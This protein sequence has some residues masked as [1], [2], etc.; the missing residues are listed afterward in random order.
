MNDSA[1]N[2]DQKDRKPKRGRFLIRCLFGLAWLAVLVVLF[3]AEENWRGARALESYKR[4]LAARGATLDWKSF[5]PPPVPD[6]ENFAMT[7]FLAPLFDF[8][9]GT[10]TWRDIDARNDVMSFA[11][12]FPNIPFEG[13]WRVGNRINLAAW[14]KEPR[15]KRKGRTAEIDQ[16]ITTE[17]A[18]AASS[19]LATLAEYDP[20]IE[21]L[22]TASQRSQSR[23][24]IRYD[25]DDLYSIL[26]PHLAV[27][28]KA[29]QILTARSAARLAI[30]QA[31]PAFNDVM[32]MIHL[33]D[34]PK[35][36]PFLISQLVRVA[37]LQMT[38]QII[39]EGFAGHQWSDGQLRALQARLVK[40]NLLEDLKRSLEGERAGANWSINQVR[41][42]RDLEK[43]GALD[44]GEAQ[45]SNDSMREAVVAY[46]MCP[47]GWYYLEQLNY[48]WMFDESIVTGFSATDQ[49]VDAKRC[50]ENRRQMDAALGTSRSLVAKHRVFARLLLPALSGTIKKMALAQNAVDEAL[51][52]CALERFRLSKGQYPESLDA[53]APQFISKLPH[54][55]MNGEP[56]KY[57]RTEDSQFILYSV[58]WNEVDDGGVI[59][60][61]Q[62]SPNK[63]QDITQGDWVWPSPAR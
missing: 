61:T 21:E 50:E 57:R 15:T 55:V 20:V 46:K 63:V 51:V 1:N 26:L 59:A 54:D 40:F 39:W 6:S 28:K 16:T 44:M 10:Q 33:V 60:R 7:P 13:G 41:V 32:L 11:K 36:E 62:G 24:N 9:P 2:P 14:G 48:N 47:A 4:Q 31:E 12:D 23:F 18:K 38:M 34:A 30:G 37:G 27:L 5:V 35:S 22:R 3:Y 8:I 29:C 43:V 53:L 17:R 45:G 42:R 56:L 58:G 49:R 19:S 25:N 52:A